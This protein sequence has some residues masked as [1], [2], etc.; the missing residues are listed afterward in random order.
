MRERS[1][2]VSGGM[3]RPAA[4]P[5][6]KVRSRQSRVSVFLALTTQNRQAR[7]LPPHS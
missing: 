7:R 5:A 4:E 2:R 6:I 1:G 3:V